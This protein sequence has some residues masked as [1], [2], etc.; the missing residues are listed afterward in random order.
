MRQLVTLSGGLFIWT[1]TTIRFIESDFHDER[2]KKSS[3]HQ[4]TARCMLGWTTCIGS[5]LLIHSTHDKSEFNIVQSILGAIVVAREQ[6]T[7]E[8]LSRLLGPEIGD[9]RVVLS[10]LQPVLRGVGGG[11]WATCSS[12]TC[13]FYRFFV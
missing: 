12:L 4:R 10:R 1:S 5:L 2:L 6:L 3:V 7:D 8:Q 9:V 11:S 13:I